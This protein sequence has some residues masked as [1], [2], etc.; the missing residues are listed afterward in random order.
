[1][2]GSVARITL[3]MGGC[4]RKS[5]PDFLFS[6]IDPPDPRPRQASVPASRL[7]S[8][9]RREATASQGGLALPWTHSQD[10]GNV[11]KGTFQEKR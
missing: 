2:H 6:A 11:A 5:L 3:R 10:P 1:M 7:G 8:R 4:L 9:L